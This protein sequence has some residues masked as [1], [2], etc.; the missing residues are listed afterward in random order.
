MKNYGGRMKK[1]VVLWFVLTFSF[2]FSGFSHAVDF[3]ADIINSYQGQTSLSKI[4]VTTD[5]IRIE[6]PGADG[7][8]VLRMD[9]KVIWIVLPEEKTYI[10]VKSEQTQ[11]AG[12]KMKGEISRK[13]LSSETVNGYYAKKYEVQYRDKNTVHTVHQWVAS[14]LSYPIKI[15]AVD[16]SWGTEYRNIQIG[17]QPDVL[18][19]IPEGFDRISRSESSSGEQIPEPA[20]PA[21]E[22]RE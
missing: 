6:A 7:Y 15:S 9:K 4:F 2:A 21:K 17:V 1:T 14:D 11:G 12:E 18:F 20:A 5:K 3:T 8:T 16:G 10:E 19:E 22:K 13:Y